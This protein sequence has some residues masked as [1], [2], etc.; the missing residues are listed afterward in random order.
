VLSWIQKS[1]SLTVCA[2]VVFVASVGRMVGAA[3]TSS[4]SFYVLK[5]DLAEIKSRGSIRFL[6]HGETDYLPRAGDPRAAERA[7]AEELANRLGLQPV[8]VSVAEQDDLISQLNDGNGDVI[9]GS[10]AITAERSKRIA[11]S[12]PIRF[13]DQLVVVKTSDTS[14]QPSKI[15][16]VRR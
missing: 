2:A 10:L 4:S 5:G 7:S 15:Y 12:R 13:V 9:V 16:R 1:V 3:E 8:F 14:I 11:F 6:V